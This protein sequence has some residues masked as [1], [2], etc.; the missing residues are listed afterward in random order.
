MRKIEYYFLLYIN[1]AVLCSVKSI[2]KSIIDKSIELLIIQTAMKRTADEIETTTVNMT[3]NTTQ[4]ISQNKIQCTIDNGVMDIIEKLSDGPILLPGLLI[5]ALLPAPSTFDL[6]SG[7]TRYKMSQQ[8][9]TIPRLLVDPYGVGFDAT[10]YTV[11]PASPPILSPLGKVK[12]WQARHD[13]SIGKCIGSLLQYCLQYTHS[14][15]YIPDKNSEYYS[16][17]DWICLNTHNNIVLYG[18]TYAVDA[19]TGNL[20]RRFIQTS[21]IIM[22]DVNQHGAGWALTLSGLYNL[23]E[24]A[25]RKIIHSLHTR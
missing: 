6:V 24:S 13:H 25:D 16:A 8:Q 21:P 22:Y 3:Q 1:N 17:D 20:Y 9:H 23:C 4:N 19:A 12:F 15:P 14:G 18:W 10:N 7:H 2:V 11:M 5:D